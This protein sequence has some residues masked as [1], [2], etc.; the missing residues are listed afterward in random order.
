[1]GRLLLTGFIVFACLAGSGCRGASADESTDRT[2]PVKIDPT[3]PE[4]TLVEQI[5]SGSTQI[6]GVIDTLDSIVAQVERIDP[7]KDAELKQGLAD[8]G[9]SLDSAGASLA[10]FADDRPTRK[11]VA[12]RF[13]QFDEWRIQAIAAVNDALHD[14]DDARGLADQFAKEK[15]VDALHQVGDLLD[16]AISDLEDA[17]QTLGGKAEE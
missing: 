8:L 16:L 13:A 12:A 6:D 11:E 1:M 10:N 4:D 3:K 15:K 7:K 17:L 5:R 2:P 9:E 14:L